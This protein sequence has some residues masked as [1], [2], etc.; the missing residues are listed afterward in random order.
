LP[1]ILNIKKIINLFK[2]WTLDFGDC[3][4]KLNFEVSRLYILTSNL[5]LLG[6]KFKAIIH[7]IFS[8]GSVDDRK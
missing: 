4:T 7:P 6:L 2:G 5:L 8:L 3:N 1:S